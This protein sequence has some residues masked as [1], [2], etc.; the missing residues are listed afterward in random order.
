MLLKR[1][2]LMDVW[3]MHNPVRSNF[4]KNHGQNGTSVF[5]QLESENSSVLKLD[6]PKS[7]Q[8]GLVQLKLILFLLGEK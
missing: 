5:S 3:G 7:V 4:G 8:M 2:Q 1:K 6:R